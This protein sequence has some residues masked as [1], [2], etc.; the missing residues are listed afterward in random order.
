MLTHV[1]V[2]HMPMVVEVVQVITVVVVEKA[3]LVQTQVLT[4]LVEVVHHIMVTHR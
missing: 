1:M 4:V 2:D 3:H